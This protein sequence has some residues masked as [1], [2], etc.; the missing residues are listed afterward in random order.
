MIVNNRAYS[1]FRY[2]DS[3]VLLEHYDHDA[4]YTGNGYSSI[5]E[6]EKEK[7]QGERK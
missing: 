5:E 2:T 4:V 1:R 7:I 6:K 3:D